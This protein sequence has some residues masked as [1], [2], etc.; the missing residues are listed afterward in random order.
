M[1][2]APA[3][4]VALLTIL[5][6]GG[7]RKKA[8][9]APASEPLAPSADSAVASDAPSIVFLGDSLTVGYGLAAEEALPMLIQKKIEAE[10]MPYRVINAGRSGDT[11]AGG[12]ARLSWYL[13]DSVHLYALV[14]GLGSN[15]AMR[16]LSL[17]ELDKN[18]R[19][20]IRRTRAFDAKVR[21]F[22]WGMKTFPNMGA[23]YRGA[24]EQVFA[25]VA[26]EE[27]VEL[28]PFP[29]EGVAGDPALNQEDGIHPTAAG[30]RRV[31]DN[32]WR[33]LEP[34]L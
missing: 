14:I 13:R 16:G 19:E 29:L 23:E 18:L 1:R 4:L 8:E 28:I 15:D 25:R 17:T 22:L 3:A 10:R 21:I 9:P 20:I 7:C 2:F 6:A 32:V 5:C 34:R 27:K 11:S 12:L 31:A 26:V 30:T 24:Y 33:V